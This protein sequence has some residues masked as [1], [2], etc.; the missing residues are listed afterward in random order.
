M[1]EITLNALI[2]LFALFSAI[3]E[4]KKEDAVRNFRYTFISTLAFLTKM[5]TRNFS[6]SCS[7][8]TGLTKELPSPVIWFWKFLISVQT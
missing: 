6:K 3:S 8:F 4:S 7:I 5:N 2:N 1:N